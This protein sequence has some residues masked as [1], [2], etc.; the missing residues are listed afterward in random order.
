MDLRLEG[1]TLTF[2][3]RVKPRSPRERLT[4]DPSGELR[5]E[6]H[7]A[8]TEGQANAAGIEFLA[9]ILRLPKSS[10]SIVTGEKSRRKLLRIAAPNP[11]E[12]ASQL[13]GL[14]EDK[15]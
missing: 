15:G 9:H 5:L 7:A 13:R 8:A 6:I 4:T 3:L 11:A 2:W 10:I 12:V 14:A 1:N